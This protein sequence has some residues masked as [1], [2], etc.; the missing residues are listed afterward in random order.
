MKRVSLNLLA[1]TLTF[2]STSARAD[3]W[4]QWMGA[5]REG[6][7]KET[8]LLEKFP[9]GGPKVLW[10][11]PIHNGYS[12][13]A[14]VGNR[15]FVMDR[16]LETSAKQP[17]NPF[18]RGQ[19]PGNERVLCLDATS[20]KKI[21]EHS[22][23][24]DY[25]VSYA[26]GPR[27]TPTVDGDRVYTLGAEGNLL[28]LKAESGD[29]IWSHDFKKLLGLKTPTWGFTASPLV[30]GDLLICLAG[31]DGTT[32]IAFDKLTGEQ[33]WSELSS[34]EPGYAPP[35]IVEHEGRRLLIIWHPESV[36]ALDPQTGK[37]FW[38]VGWQLRSGL[39]V[40]TPRLRGD[41]L[42]FS[43]FYNGSMMLKLSPDNTA[44]EIVW[45]TERASENPARTT[46]L[47]G[48]MSTP[49]FTGEYLYGACSYGEFRCLEAASGERL[50][51]TLKPIALDKPTRWG[52]VFITENAGRYFLFTEKGDLVIAKLSPAGYEEIDRAHVIE[53]DGADMRQR[54][55][56]WSHPAYARKCCFVRN[57]S[58]IICISLAE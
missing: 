40:A 32:A 7:W 14:V 28:C 56:V 49:V 23:D 20:G 6:I 11:T 39:S 41:H 35:K 30:D 9:D 58:D 21:W 13:P 22:Y 3:D 31:G 46:H 55:I 18:K 57:D 29:V 43:C 47:H 2:F 17:D 15:V 48:I 1:L 16:Q 12:G 24:C 36:N 26:S 53:P 5:D 4:A 38:T 42:F 34:K 50:W 19:I 52:N 27:T 54:K 51:D 25:T 10:R 45:R 8:G 33:R 37:V 44:P